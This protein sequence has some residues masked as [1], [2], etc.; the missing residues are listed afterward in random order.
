MP[1]EVKSTRK[2]VRTVRVELTEAEMREACIA[3]VLAEEKKLKGY[4]L[5]CEI[6]WQM[7]GRGSAAVITGTATTERGDT[8]PD[9]A[10]GELPLEAAA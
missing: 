8:A 4:D 3:Y 2:I 10:P 9:V 1:I 5:A 6:V 7:D